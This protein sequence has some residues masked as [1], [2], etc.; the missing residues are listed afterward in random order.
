MSE[1][2]CET[3][4]RLYKVKCGS[5]QKFHTGNSTC[6]N[7]E[8]KLEEKVKNL[9]SELEYI[10]KTSDVD[11]L[12]TGL[13]DNDGKKIHV[14]DIVAQ[15]NTCNVEMHGP[16]SYYEIVLRGM[17]IMRNYI[18]S[19]YGQILPPGYTGGVLSDLCDQKLVLYGNEAFCE[20]IEV[21]DELPP[22]K[23]NP[24]IKGEEE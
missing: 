19:D 16:K 9:Q 11:A 3:C 12:Y 18:R 8:W 10:K 17:I 20:G 22:V 15:E 13:L 7:C 14:G 1:E 4:N 23:T 6:N 24:K 21:I 5:C 2:H